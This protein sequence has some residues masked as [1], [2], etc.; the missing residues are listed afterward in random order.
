MTKVIV[1]SFKEE[2]KAISALHKLVEL[3]SFGDI[4]IYDKI[5]VRKKAN[6]DYEILKEDGS[7]EWRTI[8]G[9]AVGGLIGLLGGPVGVVIGLCTGTVIGGISE[10]SHYNLEGDFLAKIEKSMPVGEISIVAEI[11][12]HSI[13]FID[14]Y[15][16]PFGAKVLRSDVDFEFDQYVK[17]D[18]DEIDEDIA[19]ASVE[20]K[21]S[22]GDEKVKIAKKIATMKAKRKLI[23]TEFETA[24]RNGIRNLED[25]TEAGINKIKSEVKNIGENISESV[26]GSRESRI[27]GRIASYEAKLKDLK[28]E[29]KEI[30]LKS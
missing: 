4:S 24:S 14:T 7:N 22:V 1:A 17:D 19:D 9:M 26:K 5:M 3:D 10:S 23:I 27:K 12:E 29:L 30:Q 11:D 25:K 18:I 8:T 6:G 28:S 2:A 16:K 20:L 21:K 13:G 15:L